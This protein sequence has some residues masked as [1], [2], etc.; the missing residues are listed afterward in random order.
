V[1]EILIVCS[2]LRQCVE[3][4][5]VGLADTLICKDFPGVGEDVVE[6]LKGAA[7]PA[8]GLTHNAVVRK[9]LVYMVNSPDC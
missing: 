1:K 7:Q 3:R 4:I 9:K 8:L 5:Q 6:Q 2:L